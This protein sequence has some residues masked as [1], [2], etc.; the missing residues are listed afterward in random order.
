MRQGIGFFYSF[1][2][3]TPT[4]SERP[5]G[6]PLVVTVVL[7]L[8]QAMFSTASASP[9]DLVFSHAGRIG[10]SGFTRG[11]GV[12]T[13][14]AGN[15]YCTGDFY[16]TV[17]FDPGPAVS[18]LT[19]VGDRDVYLCK[20]DASGNFQWALAFGSASADI[21]HAVAVD[22]SGNVYCAGEFSDTVDFDPGPGVFN[23][24]DAS[25]NGAFVAKFDSAGNFLWAGTLPGGGDN[26]IAVD[27][28]GNV[29][30]TSAFV[31]T[32]D[33][34][35][36][37]GVYNLTS[38]GG[39]D[40][41]IV[42]L[43]T[44]GTFQWAGAMGGSDNERGRGIT[45]DGAGNVYATGNF[46]ETA[47]FDPGPGVSNITN[48]DFSDVF[49]VKLDASGA[50]QWV[51][52]I[53][54][55]YGN[56]IATDGAAN[57][58]VTG[59]FGVS[60]DFD[61]GPGVF[62][63]N[64]TD[65]NDIFV[66]KLDTTGGFQWAGSME[67]G[68]SDFGNEICVDNAG[69]VFCV[70]KFDGTVDF[71]PGPGTFNLSSA[72]L[73]DAFVCKLD[74]TGNFLWAGR[75]GGVSSDEGHSIALDNAGNVFTT[76]GFR[77]G[78]DY[79]PGSGVFS[80]TN[81]AVSDTYILKLEPQS[82]PVAASDMGETNADQIL[83]TLTSPPSTS[84]LTNDTDMNATATLSV[85]SFDAVSVLGAAVSVNSD[86][87]FVYD[88]TGA[89]ALQGIAAGAT[90]ADSFTYTVGDGIDTAVGTVTIAVYG[91]G[92][93]LPALGNGGMILLLLA[94][95]LAGIGFQPRIRHAK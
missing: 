89:A 57:V 28:G 64:P 71:D 93:G 36:G 33:F 81:T 86:G 62:T 84:V 77:G 56:G 47:D 68:N 60:G 18:N 4:S 37:P 80:L 40:A 51:A 74:N 14:S 5:T 26:D 16:S 91:K 15:V 10:G 90:M 67:G 7:I 59:N 23:L 44:L 9:D 39:A 43:D 61:P 34:D 8:A 95:I 2:R 29:Y 53:G 24:S 49:V 1:F 45:A 79:D 76:G 88:P 83:T 22:T 78:G 73:G 72:G 55:D 63:L 54:A 13:D 52:A 17:D 58:Y 3:S 66:V 19:A 20:L 27:S 85:V 92:T 30:C 94:M 48:G 21:G 11:S 50:F 70:G 12:A 32:R 41:Y 35:P 42:K 69:T 31:G 6:L 25:G 38:A 87:T 75:M 82:I 46:T 65:V